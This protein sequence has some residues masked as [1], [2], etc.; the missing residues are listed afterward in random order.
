MKTAVTIAL[1]ALVLGTGAGELAA[2]GRSG[3]GEKERGKPAAQSNRGPQAER[4]KA[5]KGQS[6]EARGN[7]QKNQ[8][9]EARGEGAASRGRGQGVANGAA[10]GRTKIRP[11]SLRS[12]IERLTPEVR[13]FAGS[14]RP[15]ERLVGRAAARAQVRGT[16][17]DAFNVRLVDDRIRV[18]NRRGE[19]LLDLDEER[20]RN[21][22]AWR[23][24]PVDDDRNEGSPAFCRSGE[25]HP[26]WGREWCIQKG[27]GLGGGDD[28]FWSR[29]RVDDVIFRRPVDTERLD[30]G[31]LL[32]V[33]GD[34]VLGR[35]AL[36]AITLGLSDPLTGTW[37]A[38]D[39]AP[40]VL[41][42][43]AGGAPVAEFIDID[44]DE[45]VDVLY[46]RHRAW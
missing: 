1:C 37:V 38:Q 16:D 14:K 12:G 27:F 36:H 3:Q 2:Q 28:V 40:R 9:P 42:I 20:A 7:A 4:A 30:R 39:N 31:T 33:L 45:S 5:Q 22:G 41:R 15:H 11:A 19:V 10:R 23:M 21:L 44:R 26:V 24:R 6:P 8:R 29:G 46:V 32:D 35:L 43:D 13:R 25:G 18:Q 17:N 34:V